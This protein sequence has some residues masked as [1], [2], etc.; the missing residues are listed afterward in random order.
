[1]EIDDVKLIDGLNY[2]VLVKWGDKLSDK[3]TFGYNNDFTAFI[4]DEDNPNEGILWVNHEYIHPMFVSDYTGEERTKEQVDKE[5]YNVGGSILKV[6]KENGQW[7][8]I[9]NHP[10]N[11]RITGH[12]PIPFNW[13]SKVGGANQGIGTLANCSGGITPWKT[14][15]T[16]EEN[17]DSFYGERNHETGELITSKYAYG[18]Q[19]YYPERLP[20]HYG[21]VVEVDPVTGECQKHIGLGR[22]AHECATMFQMPDGRVVVYTGD[23]ANDQCLYKFI[24][25]EAGSLKKGKLF[26]ADVDKGE[27]IPLVY[28]EDDR[29]QAK[30]K[31]QTDL[32]IRVR[33]AARVVGGSLLARPEDIEIDPLNG[34]VLVALTNNKN[35]GNYHG[36]ILKIIEENGQHDALKFQAETHLAGGEEMGF[37]CPDNM[38]F[39]RG[40]NLWFTSDISGSAIGKE[41]Y[42]AFGN[43]ALYFVPRSGE[44]AGEV[45]RMAVAPTE[46]EFTGPW[47]SDDGSTLFLSVQHPGERSKSLDKLNSHWPD[48]GDSIPRPSVIAIPRAIAEGYSGGDIELNRPL[49]YHLIFTKMQIH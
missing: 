37:S 3:D 21:W 2:E 25:D 34:N 1:M 48:G 44:Q 45:I 26:V 43:N 4:Q 6:K 23:D 24:S 7:S 15:L 5:L 17:Y 13:D 28:K 47:F 18:H 14:I 35:K 10:I 40:G 8:V 36:E 30:F 49:L 12:T 39:D 22:C 41:P 42:Q 9:E 33:E 38:A 19:E 27:W 46:A 32:L 11:K 29:L 16:C 20:E 31:D